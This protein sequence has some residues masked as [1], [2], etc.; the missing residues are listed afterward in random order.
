MERDGKRIPSDGEILRR[1]LADD[2]DDPDAFSLIFDRYEEPVSMYL[3]RYFKLTHR[4]ADVAQETFI[5]L[6]Q[7]VERHPGV[8]PEDESI[9]PLVMFMAA[10]AAVDYIRRERRLSVM[11]TKFAIFSADES[12]WRESD[13]SISAI[14]IDVQRALAALPPSLQEVARLYFLEDLSRADVAEMTESTL[15][16]TRGKISR[17]RHLLTRHLQH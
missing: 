1:F 7:F 5:R 8:W 10:R 13:A 16:I 17:A 14:G 15:D 4:A 12:S 3:T 2:P 6:Y 9:E 11:D